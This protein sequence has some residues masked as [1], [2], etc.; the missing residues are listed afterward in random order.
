MAVKFLVSLSIEFEDE[1]RNVTHE[2]TIKRLSKHVH[3]VYTRCTIKLLIVSTSNCTKNAN[4]DLKKS[5]LKK[6]LRLSFQTERLRGDLEIF[7]S[8][9]VVFLASLQRLNLFL[10]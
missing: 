8:A 9:L 6:T 3:F 7:F 4:I 1:F 10:I 2:T 5:T